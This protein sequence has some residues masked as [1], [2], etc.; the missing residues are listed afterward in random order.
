[1]LHKDRI[2]KLLRSSMKDDVLIGIQLVKEHHHCYNI[3]K[4]RLT[5]NKVYEIPYNGN[6]GELFIWDSNRYTWTVIRHS[7]IFNTI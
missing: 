5:I 1:M 4:L 6:E 2:Q 3:R 7:E